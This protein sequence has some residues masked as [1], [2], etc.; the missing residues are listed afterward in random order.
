MQTEN[1]LTVAGTR[2]RVPAGFNSFYLFG[3]L[4]KYFVLRFLTVNII[5]SLLSV[6]VGM[7][8]CLLVL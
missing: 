4:L 6:I 8:L 1:N 2:A 5:V 3:I 7:E